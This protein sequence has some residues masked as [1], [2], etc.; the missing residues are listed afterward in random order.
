MLRS[1]T[2]ARKYTY[3]TYSGRRM[4]KNAPSPTTMAIALKLALAALPYLLTA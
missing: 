1:T 2:A 4:P 3:D